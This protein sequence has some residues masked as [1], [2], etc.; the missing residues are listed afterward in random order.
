MHRPK[1][2]SS[3]VYSTE[4]GRMCPGCGNAVAACTCGKATAAAQGD[5]IVRVSRETKGRKGKGVT[6]VRGVSLEPLA[7][8]QLGK[9]L[10]TACGSGGTVKDGVIEIQGDHCDTVMEKLRQRG[11]TVKRAGG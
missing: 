7:L 11:M 1:S 8:A 5:G 4:Q 3:L 10:K 6:L 2:A 9:E